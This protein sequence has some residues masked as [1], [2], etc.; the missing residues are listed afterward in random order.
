MRYDAGL[1]NDFGGGDVNWWLDYLRA[2][3]ERSHDFYA[4]HIEFLE[5]ELK[6]IERQAED[7]HEYVLAQINQRLKADHE[8]AVALVI[9][10]SI[11]TG[12]ADT[13]ADLMAEVLHKVGELRE[14]IK[15]LRWENSKAFFRTE[16]GEWTLVPPPMPPTTDKE[17]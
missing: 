14:E 3:L 10:A 4:D 12:N 6:A 11:A 7:Q 17:E 1:L 9:E 15:L 16:E 2:E 13:S 8:A 5:A